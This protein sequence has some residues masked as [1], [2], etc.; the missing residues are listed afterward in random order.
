MT[1]DVR[2]P[3]LDLEVQYGAIRHEVD[4]A[5][6]RV[7]DS[8][9]FVLG[10]EVRALEQEIAAYCG[11]PHAVACASGSDA[12][13]LVLMALGIGAG[14]EVICPAYSF[15]ASA[16]V[17]AR[18]GA[19]PV[20]AD[21]DP[22]TFNA[23]A[24]TLREA[25]DRCGRPRAIMAVHLYGQ[26][27]NMGEILSLSEQLDLPVIE[28]AAQSIGARDGDGRTVGSRGVAGC[29]SFYPTKNLG[30]FG[31]GGIVTTSDGH[32]AERLKILREHGAEPDHD[33]VEI[34]LNSR[35]DALQA[36]VLRVKLRSLDGWSARRRHN[37]ALY[38]ELFEKAG[39]GVGPGDFGDLL[40]PVRVPV[41]AD[42]PAVQSFNQFVIRV[43]GEARNGLRD[44]LTE[45]AVGSEIYYRR[46]LHLNS[47]FRSLDYVEGDFPCAELAA[48]ENLALPIY[49]ELE[50]VQI[51]RVV[52]LI[53]RYFESG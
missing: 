4:A 52:E 14:D 13:L 51:R 39:G 46:P 49:P 36:A 42:S 22:R 45:H 6:R 26:A 3:L 16:G 35:L 44:H 48:R 20:F 31:D 5:L 25:A 47:C 40:L 23:S 8:Q 30:G 21:I 38:A 43:P 9:H 19:I 27:S 41:V 29:F 33:H 24:E 28:D 17:I 37:A 32:L 7:L 10:P 11:V 1:D 50:E 18:L 53:R 15:F 2:V 12:L 34:G